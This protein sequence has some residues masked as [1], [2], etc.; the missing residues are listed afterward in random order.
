M[1]DECNDAIMST[2]GAVVLRGIVL[3]ASQV[4][5]QLIGNLAIRVHK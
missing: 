4:L 3:W 5:D 2:N 1:V